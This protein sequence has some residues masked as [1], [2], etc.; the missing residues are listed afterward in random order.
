[1]EIKTILT[2]PKVLSPIK[3]CERY[4]LRNIKNERAN[5]K[6][7]AIW[8][9][10]TIIK[11]KKNVIMLIKL[12]IILLPKPED[13]S[14]KKPWV[15]PNIDANKKIEIIKQKA[16]CRANPNIPSLANPTANSKIK[17]ANKLAQQNKISPIKKLIKQHLNLI[18][19]TN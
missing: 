2:Q 9:K 15:S 17:I 10:T 13:P 14:I 8:W 4:Q 16:H 12:I 19:I 6:I 1:M 11:F 5:W 18:I 3:N 7:S